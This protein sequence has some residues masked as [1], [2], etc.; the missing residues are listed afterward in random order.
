MPPGET[1]E[2][3]WREGRLGHNPTSLSKVVPRQYRAQIHAVG[4]G[5]GQRA[6]QHCRE[7]ARSSRHRLFAGSTG[8][9]R[10][11]FEVDVCHD[12]G[13]FNCLTFPE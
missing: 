5:R 12:G 11:E 10:A 13:N 6:G 1:R 4:N 7:A 2:F 9:E 3:R 8:S